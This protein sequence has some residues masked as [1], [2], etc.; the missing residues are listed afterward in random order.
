MTKKPL[1]V[2]GYELCTPK[3]T[4]ESWDEDRFDNELFETYL[5][6]ILEVP[7]KERALK[8]KK[9]NKMINLLSLNQSE[10]ADFLEGVF[11]T[12][13]YGKEQTII[14]VPNQEEAGIKEKDHGVLNEVYFLVHKKTGLFLIEKDSEGVARASMIRRF[15]KFH[16]ELIYDY[17]AKFNAQFTP[18]KIM[19]YSF[20]RINS[21][22]SKTFFEELEEFATIKDAYYY[23]DFEAETGKKNNEAA[24]LFY[25]YKVAKEEGVEDITRVKVSFENKVKKG[26]VKHIKSF[27]QKLYESQNYDGIGVSGQLRSGRQRTIELENIQKGY[28]ISVEHH[29][30]GSPSLQDLF[31]EMVKKCKRD[32][33]IDYKKDIEQYKGVLIND[34]DT[35]EDQAG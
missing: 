12:A 9:E 29:E 23:K 20:I 17:I 32:N 21:L 10:D 26:S 11:S 7:L 3:F 6:L 22:P 33:P 15:L 19:K 16:K 4:G 35:E 14:D 25:H 28:D 1:T 2:L 5:N 34:N 30:N 18:I 31:N 27:F 24:D 13:K 8:V